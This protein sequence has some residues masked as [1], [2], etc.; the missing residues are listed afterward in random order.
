MPRD[1]IGL[2]FVPCDVI[3]VIG[4]CVKFSA[5]GEHVSQK[6]APF[7]RSSSSLFIVISMEALL[8]MQVTNLPKVLELCGMPSSMRFLVG[9]ASVALICGALDH[10]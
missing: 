2:V 8:G 5:V 3:F 6:P 4:S 1:I 10:L 9:V 7:R